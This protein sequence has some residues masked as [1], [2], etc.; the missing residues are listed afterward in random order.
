METDGPLETGYGPG[1]PAGDN[2]CND[3]VQGLAS[4]YGSLARARGDRVEEDDELLLTDR[5]SPTPFG[6]VVVVRQ[7]LTE[8]GWRGAIDRI[9]HF[10]GGRTGGDCL[11]FSAWTTPDL[12]VAGFGRV[13]HPPLMLR[14]PGPVEMTPVAGLEVRLV[15]DEQSA[16]DC[17]RVLVEGFPV[18]ELLPFRRGT[19]LPP[20]VPEVA[21]WRHWVAYLD[22]EAVATA[23]AYVGDHHVDVEWVATV[24]QAR[25]RGGGRA[26]TAAAT[27]AAPDLP[28]MLIASDDGRPVYERLGYRAL[29][30]FTLWIGHRAA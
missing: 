14:P 24:E 1:A 19:L 5:G 15:D 30:R 11:V 8:D 22:G 17:E 26:V 25:R 18:P 2:A 12:R 21:G 7:P 4:A 9:R 16:E 20:G 23:S 13:G 3:Y 6:N 27:A 29:L 10:Y 28:A